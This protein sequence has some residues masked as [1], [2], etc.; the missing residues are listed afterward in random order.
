[1]RDRMI[2]DPDS[3]RV[4]L[5]AGAISA[6]AIFG[7]GL[8]Y[9]ASDTPGEIMET[10]VALSYD[11]EFE[12]VPVLLTG[13]A[14]SVAVS[15]TGYAVSLTVQGCRRHDRPDMRFLESAKLAVL[16]YLLCLDKGL[17]H[18]ILKLTLASSKEESIYEYKASA[19]F[20]MSA[21]TALANRAMPF[22]R[23]TYLRG[24]DGLPATREL[25]FPYKEM[26]EA[27]Y[28]FIHEAFRSVKSS[29]RLLVSAPTGTGKT[30]S[31]LYPAVRL[32]GEGLADKVFCLCAKTTVGKAFTDAAELLAVRA[33]LLRCVVISSKERCCPVRDMKGKRRSRMCSNGCALYATVDG[34]CAELRLIEAAAKCLENSIITA[35]VIKAIAEYH[36]VCPHEL[37]LTVSEYCDIIVCDYN[38]VFD[39]RMRLRRYFDDEHGSDERFVFLA[40]EVHN[41]PARATDTY[42]A[43]LSLQVL[44]NLLADA[45]KLREDTTLAS[46]V[47]GVI[48]ELELLRNLALKE[49]DSREVGGE[50]IRSGFV[51][52]RVLPSKLA[53]VT[54]VLR[55]TLGGV[56]LKY[57]DTLPPIF[58]EAAEAVGKFCH[59]CSLFDRNYTCFSSAIGDEF[60]LRLCCLDPAPLL[61]QAM[62]KARAVVFFSATLTPISY[63][64][65]ILGCGRGSVLE[66]ESP[67]RRE[68]LCPVAVDSVSMKLSERNASADTVAECIA[69]VTE[70]KPGN[71]LAFFPSFDYMERVLKLFREVSPDTEVA[72]QQR[73]MKLA[74][75]EQF[76]SAFRE[77]R[78]EF[79]SLVGFAV[80]GGVFSESVDLP[81]DSL[82]GVIIAGTGMPA[83]TSERN[84]MRDYFEETR[85]GGMEYAYV[86]PG[87]NNVLQAAGRVIRTDTDRGVLVLIDSRYSEPTYYKL[88]PKYWRHIRYTGDPFS[89]EEILRR[90]WDEE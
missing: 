89:L 43:D 5:S 85:E 77:E 32:I 58:T 24:R 60:Y 87:F 2:Y 88:F 63:Y 31:A 38:Y 4:I 61:D 71:Y 22:I 21:V 67:F 55:R 46:A 57:G 53:E 39:F 69:A 3:G 42:S 83:I 14:E 78:D 36:T 20:L 49:G 8:N 47:R 41:L 29:S 19:E 56:I 84:I 16:G 81:G 6:F 1:M 72:V 73:S 33:P 48:C 70:A 27:Q 51:S 17:D 80:L 18:V 25:P 12:G 45:E 54:G 15:A 11:L 52:D 65:D 74:A 40:D 35:D 59:V 30:I 13:V 26:R 76:L 7:R 9:V 90:F 44:A 64:A 62:K 37:S 66:L 50:M 75:R 23:H 10:D 86:Y 34:K 82:I 28:E 79:T 68:N